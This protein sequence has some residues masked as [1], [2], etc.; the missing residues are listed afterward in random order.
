MFV[1]D[2]GIVLTVACTIITVG[3]TLMTVEVGSREGDGD[4]VESIKSD[5]SM[6]K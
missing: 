2:G 3:A 5:E 4:T 1:G 6:I